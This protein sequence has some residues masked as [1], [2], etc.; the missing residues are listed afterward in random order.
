M[1]AVLQYVIAC[2]KIEPELLERAMRLARPQ[3]GEELMGTIAERWLQEG[4]LEGIQEGMQKGMQK[5]EA[6]TLVRLLERRF[7]AV[8]DAV[9]EDVATASLEQLDTWLDAVVDAESLDEVFGGG[10]NG[11][12]EPA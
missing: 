12:K 9:R 5:G 1:L 2:Y 11:P 4:R 8:P 6:N 10:G 3:D 7:G